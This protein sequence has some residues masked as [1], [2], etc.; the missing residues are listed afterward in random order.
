MSFNGI[1]CHTTSRRKPGPLLCPRSRFLLQV[2]IV[3]VN[4]TMKVTKHVACCRLPEHVTLDEGAL[5][6]P[7][8][9]G[10]HGCKRADVG[11][12]SIVLVLGA[13]PIGLVTFLAARAFGASKILITG[14]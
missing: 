2:Q 7:L 5:L 14:N 11:V 12:D 13:G 9:V 4:E 1:L 3:E 10:V 8:S 6:E